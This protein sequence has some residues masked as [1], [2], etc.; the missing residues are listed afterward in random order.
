M[1]KILFVVVLTVFVLSACGTMPATSLPV[2]TNSQ[3]ATITALPTSTLTNTPSPTDTATPQPTM[4]PFPIHLTINAPVFIALRYPQFWNNAVYPNGALITENFNAFQN[5]DT[6]AQ[7]IGIFVEN[8]PDISGTPLE[9]LEN[10]TARFA[11]E[12]DQSKI[13][14]YFSNHFEQIGAP[15]VEE[16]N[17]QK[18]V[19]VEYNAQDESGAELHYFLTV[20]TDGTKTLVAFA[21]ISIDRIDETRP[22]FCNIVRSIELHIKG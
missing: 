4:T 17:G 14:P 19:W 2:P 18:F 12:K 1:K 10:I 9:T 5:E 7:T 3:V 6:K 13:A 11:G 16:I 20:I 22:I 15:M 21:S 8:V